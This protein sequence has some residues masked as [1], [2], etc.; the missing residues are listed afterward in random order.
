MREGMSLQTRREL[1]QHMLP[2]YREVSSVRKKSKLLDAFTATTGHHRR[3]TMQ[4]LNHARLDRKS[5]GLQE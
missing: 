5:W 2:Q 3:Y 4:L 1:L